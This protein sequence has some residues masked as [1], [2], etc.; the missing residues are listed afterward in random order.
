MDI[1]IINNIKSLAIDMIENASSGH[2]GICL[3]SAPIIYTL[4]SRHLNVS[5]N[6]TDWISRDRFVLSAGHGSALLYATLFMA[7]FDLSI[8][9]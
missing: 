4:Y 5:T 1:E 8:N 9:D 3:S 7:G 6:D 2:P